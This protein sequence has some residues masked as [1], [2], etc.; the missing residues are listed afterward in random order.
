MTDRR[1]T[2]QEKCRSM[3]NHTVMK[4]LV[5]GAAAVGMPDNR[6]GNR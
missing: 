6:H 5:G 4:T 1:R 2:I 3:K